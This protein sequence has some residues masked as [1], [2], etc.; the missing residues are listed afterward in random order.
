MTLDLAN[1][2]LIF[3][4]PESGRSR[5]RGLSDNEGLAASERTIA[6]GDE[7]RRSR[8]NV[9]QAC[10]PMAQFRRSDRPAI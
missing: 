5:R 10:Y 4:N 2:L 1:F 9:I 3:T 6:V 7:S 8:P